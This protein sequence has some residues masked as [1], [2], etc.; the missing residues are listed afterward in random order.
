MTLSENRS[1]RS[2]PT[3][4]EWSIALIVFAA[5]LLYMYRDPIFSGFEVT[6]GDRGDA[7]FYIFYLEHWYKV[8][9]GVASMADPPVFFPEKGTLGYADAQF[10][11]ALPYAVFRFFGADPFLAFQLMAF[12][13]NFVG[14]VAMF[15]LSRYLIGAP[16]WL[17][18]AAAFAAAF[19]NGLYG[20]LSHAQMLTLNYYP[21]I[22]LFWTAA[23]LR[24]RERPRQ[25]ALLAAA[26]GLVLAA[27]LFTGFYL[28]FFFVLLGGLAILLYL[29]FDFRQIAGFLALHGRKTAA[30]VGAGFLACLV[31]LIPFFMVHLP[32]VLTGAKRSFAEVMHYSPTAADLLNV[33]STNLLWGWIPQTF[34]S[35]SASRMMWGE[36]TMAPTPF[37]VIGAIG[38]WLWLVRRNRPLSKRRLRISAAMFFASAILLGMTVNIDGTSGWWL[39][40]KLVPGGSGLRVPFRIGMT[41]SFFL[42][43][44][45]V[46]CGAALLKHAQPANLRWR[47]AGVLGLAILIAAGQIN[48]R[49]TAH[50]QRVAE[51]K[52]LAQLPPP[53]AAC[54]AFVAI[55]SRFKPV[56]SIYAS[57]FLQVDAMLIAQQTGIPTINGY[58]GLNPKGW[59]LMQPDQRAALKSARDWIRT[60]KLES[61]ICV[62][63]RAANAWFVGSRKLG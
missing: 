51:L 46:I 11:H 36:L 45:I 61:S 38:L 2:L 30:V 23:G 57:L 44:I 33:G 34:T 4:A 13:Q 19:P 63:D 31:G 21:I 17:A 37:L 1:A 54:K 62:Y 32:I 26:G 40:W 16:W 12:T 22:L 41:V 3:F 14:F 25:A 28:G 15:A 58:N 59:R 9:A 49:R 56:V 7:R 5:G 35:L 24:L 53:P 8:F 39:I 48:V 42:T 60:K 43:L 10:A 50:L 18:V 20:Q 27:Q 29:A 47:Q 52:W 6:I 55:D